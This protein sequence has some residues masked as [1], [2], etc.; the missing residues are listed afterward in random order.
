[1]RKVFF[2]ALL[3]MLIV[4]SSCKGSIPQSSITASFY[5][6]TD[7]K[8][9][10]QSYSCNISKLKKNVTEITFSAPESLIGVSYSW[11][12]G[13]CSIKCGSSGISPEEDLLPKGSCPYLISEILDTVFNPN[14]LKSKKNSSGKYVFS[15]SCT[16]GDFDLYVNPET[17]FIEKISVPS[18]DL[19]AELYS[20]RAA[21]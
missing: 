5:A 17:G 13:A 12:G 14:I 11:Q 19:T 1:M 3:M 16:A 21:G 7:I 18:A 20:H 8:Q 4:F 6:A 10:G 2:A 15:G 9:S